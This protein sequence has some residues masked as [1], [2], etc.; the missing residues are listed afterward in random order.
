MLIIENEDKRRK[1]RSL[2]AL[3]LPSIFTS[4]ICKT[5]QQLGKIGRTL[6]LLVSPLMFLLITNSARMT[7]LKWTIDHP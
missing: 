1:N 3:I 2:Q 6:S 7:Q 5:P 4:N